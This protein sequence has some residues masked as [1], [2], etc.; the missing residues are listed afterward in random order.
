VAVAESGLELLIPDQVRLHVSPS[1]VFSG[2]GKPFNDARFIVFGVPFDKTSTYRGGSRFGPSALREASL[3]IETYSFRSRCDLEDVPICDI[4]DLHVVDAVNETMRR[5]SAVENEVLAVSKIPVVLGGEHTISFATIRSFPRDVG[6]VCFDAHADMRDEYMGEKL[7]HAT[8]LRRIIETFDPDQVVHVGLRALCKE[9]LT[10]IQ[11]NHLRHFSMRDLR[12]HDVKEDVRLIRRAVS[13][14]GKI[15]VTIDMD[16]MDPGFAPGV[17]NPEPDGMWPDMCFSI[18][19]G[20]CDER[21]VG[22]DLV[23][24][25]PHYDS[26]ITSALGAKMLFEAICASEAARSKSEGK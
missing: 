16:V 5:V 7:M 8:F 26:G 11:K 18:L 4:G 13:D 15:Y 20:L 3:N 9:E 23:E 6:I 2:F 1:Q 12:R 14:F 24:L 22:V 21:M 10:F 17:G 19:T 25:S